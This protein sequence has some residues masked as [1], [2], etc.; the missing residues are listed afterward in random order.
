VR[1]NPGHYLEFFPNG[2]TNVARVFLFD[3]D[4]Q[5]GLRMA[6]TGRRQIVQLSNGEII[7]GVPKRL[8]IDALVHPPK[9]LIVFDVPADAIFREPLYAASLSDIRRPAR[10]R[11]LDLLTTLGFLR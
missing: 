8:I 9:V 3:E 1:L 2:V 7:S 5:L 6:L 4:T 11:C 10:T